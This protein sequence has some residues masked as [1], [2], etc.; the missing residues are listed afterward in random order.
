MPVLSHDQLYLP[1]PTDSGPTE[2]GPTEAGPTDAGPITD[3]GLRAADEPA[4]EGAVIM[5][6]TPPIPDELK[7]SFHIGELGL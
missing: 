6:L 7:S 4:G 2:E 3:E 1:L 5:S